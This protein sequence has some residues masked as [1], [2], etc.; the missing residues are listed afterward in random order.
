MAQPIVLNE[1]STHRNITSHCLLFEDSSQAST[2]KA[3][4]DLPFRPMGKRGV[5]ILPFSNDALWL[6]FD[7]K[8]ETDR[9]EW[10][11]FWDN[12]LLEEISIFRVDAAG[13]TL[14]TH[15][16][17]PY[18]EQ[19]EAAFQG[20]E[21]HFSFQLPKDSLNH[22]FLKIKS[23]RSHVGSLH[24]YEASKFHA[25]QMRDLSFRA[26]V[27]GMMILRLILVFSITLFLIREHKIKAY[28][29]VIIGRTIAYWSL[30]NI[31][32]PFFSE[33]SETV[34]KINYV[35]Y[36]LAPFYSS[37]FILTIL[38][39]KQI[40]R[41]FRWAMYG[42]MLSNLL[43]VSYTLYDF[44][45][46]NM[47][48]TIYF[49]VYSSLVIYILYIYCFVKRVN[50]YFFYSLPFLLGNLSYFIMNARLLGWLHF[51]GIFAMASFFFLS[52]FFV[53]I[54]FIGKIFRSFER[55]KIEAE[56]QLKFETRQKERLKELD[57]LKTKFF[58]TISHELR[59]PLTLIAGPLAEITKKYPSD[60][61]VKLLKSN[62]SK[63][64]KL[65]NE[66]LDIQKLEAG[67]ARP[68][69]IHSDFNIFAKRIVDSFESH[70]QSKNI[71]LF[72]E[73]K[74]TE[75]DCYFDQESLEKI[76]NNLISNALKFTPS[77]GEV[78]VSTQAKLKNTVLHFTV[79][80]NG[81]G[82]GKAHLPYVF[83]RFY[84]VA[85]SSGEIVEGTGIGL[86]LVKEL[87][88]QHKGH[89]EIDSQLKKGTCFVVEI[90]V[91]FESWKSYVVSQESETEQAVLPQSARNT[92]TEAD[93]DKA[94]ILLIEDNTE[95]RLYISE[96]LKSTYDLTE[97]ANGLEGL[98]K[99]NLQ[100]PDIIITDLMMP[101][102]H[103]TEL[104][105]RIRANEATSHIPIVMLTAR[106]DKESR[107]ENLK[108]GID[109]YLTKPFDAEELKVVLSMCLENR[110]RSRKAFE[111]GTV[112]QTAPE[113]KSEKDFIQK[114]RTYLEENHGNST[115]TV[116]DMANHMHISDTQLRRKL[117]YLTKHTP[118]E[119]LRKFRLQKAESLFKHTDKSVSEVAFEVGF[120]NLSYFS[121]TFQTEFGQLPS[122]YQNA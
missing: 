17:E 42:I 12:S 40:P 109:Q 82:I 41:I 69:I 3:L 114:L 79:K 31:F 44:S 85:D 64:Q 89:I 102:M 60:Q 83:D 68:K 20:H 16:L 2:P 50:T 22:F 115:L 8:N 77:G 119:Y 4:I 107:L 1:G 95:M 121:K 61:F 53:F 84:R 15:S 76:L 46:A 100:V 35:G 33:V 32:G 94:K 29:V 9:N 104:A 110:E 14:A 27:S 81:K 75:F 80:D 88:L 24:I 99:A 39:M 71:A 106:S 73:S 23:R 78:T 43:Q 97:A 21:P 36:S 6:K 74:E 55:E 72:F 108:T 122:E 117:K 19:K 87:V 38:P 54:F 47:K 18:A 118:N 91:D 10:V 113:Q 116:S 112:D 70:A 96:L 30:L 90:P 48:F 13:N 45:A 56:Q 26:M 101:E 120:E 37:I 98:E 111:K 92:N 62:V 34:E 57:N 25:F 63:L 49:I 105:R 58:T 51:P 65:V 28:S 7:V 5:Y 11:F 86:S 103:G 52:E 93:D 66:I 59:T 67:K